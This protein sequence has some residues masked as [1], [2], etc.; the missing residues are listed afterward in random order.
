MAKIEKDLKLVSNKLANQD[1]IQKAAPAVI[2]KEELKFKTLRDK[3]AI[4]ENLY[5]KF[6]EIKD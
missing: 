3:Y 1:F 5:R 6:E 2:E 4:M